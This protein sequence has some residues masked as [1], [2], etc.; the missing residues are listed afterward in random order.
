MSSYYSNKA[1]VSL[2]NDEYLI[3]YTSL[4]YNF[5]FTYPIASTIVSLGSPAPP[6]SSLTANYDSMPK[7]SLDS[8]ND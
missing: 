8:I 5:E 6:S 2:T 1:S 3:I 7:F 4:F